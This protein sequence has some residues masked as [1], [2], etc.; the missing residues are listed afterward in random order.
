MLFYDHVILGINLD[1]SHV[2]FHAMPC[3]PGFEFTFTYL[4]NFTLNSQVWVESFV[5]G[6]LSVGS[7]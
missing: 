6:T 4:E 2:S 7:T 1:T 3:G 5:A